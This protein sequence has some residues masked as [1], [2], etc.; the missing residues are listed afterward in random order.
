MTLSSWRTK[1]PQTPPGIARLLPGYT[2]G[3]SN[4]IAVLNINFCYVER[5]IDVP[6]GSEDFMTSLRNSVYVMTSSG[7]VENTELV[8]GDEGTEDSP[9]NILQFIVSMIFFLF[10]SKK[11]IYSLVCSVYCITI[12]MKWENF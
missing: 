2:G 7:S 8:P 1:I 6:V 10:V 12:L 3:F 11:R 9:V 5:T 4:Y